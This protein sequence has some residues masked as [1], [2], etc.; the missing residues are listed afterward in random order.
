MV[1]KPY[2]LEKDSLVFF[3][4]FFDI[5]FVLLLGGLFRMCTG[6]PLFMFKLASG[7]GAI[8][9]PLGHNR[10]LSQTRENE[11]NCTVCKG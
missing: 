6:S 3:F 7:K 2:Y 1:N 9:E 5:I 8:V 10:L 11:K 4:F